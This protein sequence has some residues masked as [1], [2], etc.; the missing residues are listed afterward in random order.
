MTDFELESKLK[1]VPLPARPPEYWDQFP[2]QVRAGLRHA[3]VEFAARSSRLPTLAWRAGFALACVI[4]AL[5]AWPAFQSALQNERT[6]R[7][8]VA[9]LPGHLRVIMQDEHGLHYLV[10]DQP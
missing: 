2:A 5:A 6:F 8:E 9:Q 7:R 4:L 10:A 3:P 1:S